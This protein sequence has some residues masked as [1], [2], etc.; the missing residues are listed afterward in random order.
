[1]IVY[2]IFGY[3]I[4]LIRRKVRTDEMY[5]GAFVGPRGQLQE[6]FEYMQCLGQL[7]FRQGRSALLRKASI[8]A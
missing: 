6:A 8:D 4:A 7:N 1:M 2:T 3:V 5:K